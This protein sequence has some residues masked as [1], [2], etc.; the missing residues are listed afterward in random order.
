[1]SAIPV[2]G[3][4]TATAY[5]QPRFGVAY[6][7]TGHGNTVLRGG[8]GRFYY[9]TGQFTNGLETAAGEAVVTVTPSNLSPATNLFASSLN[10]V[11]FT[12]A[13]AAPSAVNRT[14]DSQPYTD[15]YSF[16]ISQRLTHSALLDMGYVGNESHDLQNTAGAGS[17]IN[18]VPAGALLGQPNPASANAN[19]FRPY[20]GYGDINLATNNLYS[21]YNSL[22]VKLLYQHTHSTV[23]LNY[24]FGK[25]LGIIAPSGTTL[26]ALGATLDPF[27]LQ[28]N[29]GVQPGNR[30]HIFNAA[31][32]FDLGNPLHRNKFVDGALNGWQISG[33]VQWESGA[34]E[35][36]NSGGFNFNLQTGSAIIPGSISAANPNG[37]A[38]TNQSILGTNAIQLNPILTC[39]PLANLKPNQYINGSC[40]TL[41]TSV[42]ENGPTLLPVAYGPAFFD[43]D[44]GIFKN[45]QI[46]ESKKLQIRIQSYNFLNHPNWSFPSGTNNLTLDFAQNPTTGA[47]TQTNPNF[48]ITTGKQGNRI[49]ELVAKFFF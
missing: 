45:F 8:W 25:A 4:P 40:F 27:N 2:G 37:I 35:T 31:Y 17:N 33:V 42:G 10:S 49:V 11:P 14:D 12:A 22:Q 9:H 16:T 23:S 3:F 32:S 18:L 26:T 24:T 30:T 44:L 46:T 28:N 6:D 38:I 7:L 36:Y 20:V 43:A 19:N 21:N 15:S 47:I 48:G 41:P 29:Y 13:L 5:F 1:D 34:N 39:N